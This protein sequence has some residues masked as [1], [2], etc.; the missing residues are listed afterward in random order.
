MLLVK[1]L[2]SAPNVRK[3]MV[4]LQATAGNKQLASIPKGVMYAVKP[5]GMLRVI[6]MFRITLLADIIFVLIAMN[7]NLMCIVTDVVGQHLR[8]V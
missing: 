1:I 7:T 2:K 6:I 5:R 3:Q 8:Q 4:N